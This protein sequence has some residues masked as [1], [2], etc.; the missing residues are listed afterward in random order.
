M[1]EIAIF[2]ALAGWFIQKL[3]GNIR[4]R[5]PGSLDELSRSRSPMEGVGKAETGALLAMLKGILAFGPKERLT[6]WESLELNGC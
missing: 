2:I 4:F 5:L 3:C 1:L 6:A